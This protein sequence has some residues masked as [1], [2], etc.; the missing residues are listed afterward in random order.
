MTGWAAESRGVGAGISAQAEE[1]EEEHQQQRAAAAASA[2]LH[3]FLRRCGRC[4]RNAT[5]RTEYLLQILY[6]FSKTIA[7]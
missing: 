6:R 3:D 4:S 2:A 7:C 1:E 5:S